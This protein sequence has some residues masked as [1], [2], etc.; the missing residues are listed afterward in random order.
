MYQS[1]K[2]EIDVV[3]LIIERHKIIEIWLFC[4]RHKCSAVPMLS[5]AKHIL[6]RY[7]VP[8][9]LYAKVSIYFLLIP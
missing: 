7:A 3:Q 2:K 5:G 9:I 6:T 4:E 1:N 8:P